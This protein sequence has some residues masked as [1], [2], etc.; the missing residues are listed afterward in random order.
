[1]L[2]FIESSAFAGAV[3]RL[4]QSLKVTNQTLLKV[5]FDLDHW[6]RV[7][8]ERY[9]DGLPK[10]YSPDPTQWLFH[11]H[12]AD[13]TAPLQVAV[14]R[15]LGY[16]WPAES[17]RTMELSDEAR[18]WV[19]RSAALLPFADK[20]GIVCL[21]PVRGELAAADRLTAL[22]AAA[23]GDAW[24]ASKLDELLAAAGWAG[25][26]LDAWLRDRFFAD[27]C[28]LFHHRPFV[29]HV[30]DGLPDG[31][32]ALVNY[33]KLD[34]KTLETLIYTYVGDWIRRQRRDAAAGVDGA[35]GRLAAAETLQQRLALILHGEAPYDIFVRWKPLDQQPIGWDPDLND[36]VRL[37]I[38]PWLSVPAVGKKGAGVLRD[39]PNI[40]WEK[41]RGKDVESAPWFAVFGGERINDWHLTVGEKMRARGI[42]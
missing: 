1:M 10:P 23:Y 28:K 2:A 9:P 12:P 30:W 31:F 27:H 41:D 4:D 36:G 20:D 8:A 21:P 19:A 24:R 15:L 22:L 7:A 13:S 11:G 25:K 33:H 38:R 26:S 34:G 39:K 18:A 35:Q 14:A 5:P 42:G 3:R 37:N 29:W 16:R 32:A 17:D 40:K 6:T